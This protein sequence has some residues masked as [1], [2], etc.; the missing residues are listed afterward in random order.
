M[1]QE[2]WDE[3][4]NLQEHPEVKAKFEHMASI[5]QGGPLLAISKVKQDSTVYASV[6][7]T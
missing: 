1:K 4:F 2:Y 7:T 3:L 5:T 6:R